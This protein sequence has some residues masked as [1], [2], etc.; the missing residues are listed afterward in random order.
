VKRVH[1]TISLDMPYVG[2]ILDKVENVLPLRNDSNSNRN[3]YE[4]TIVS[5]FYF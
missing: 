5:A 1:N 3:V 4:C 2:N